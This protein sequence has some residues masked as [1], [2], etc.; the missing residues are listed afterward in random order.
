[1]IPGIG[2]CGISRDASK[3]AT[4][5]IPDLLSLTAVDFSNSGYARHDVIQPELAVLSA[6]RD[7]KTAPFRVQILDAGDFCC[8]KGLP[9]W[10]GD[11]FFKRVIK[12]GDSKTNTICDTTTQTQ[13]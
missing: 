8:N 13:T 12:W 2:V 7:P 6:P 4:V 9:I 3:S 5:V 10:N 1:M 11:N